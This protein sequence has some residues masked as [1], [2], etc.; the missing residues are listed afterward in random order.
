[1]PKINLDKQKNYF[2]IEI[3]SEKQFL[4]LKQY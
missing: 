3:D 4:I 1:M 2:E